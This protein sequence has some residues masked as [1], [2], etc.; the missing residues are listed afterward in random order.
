[1]QESKRAR[2]GHPPLFW[3]RY[4]PTPSTVTITRFFLCPKAFS[5]L[6]YPGT[7]WSRAL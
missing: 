5:G 7:E 4:F 6:L 3:P 1:M 2:G